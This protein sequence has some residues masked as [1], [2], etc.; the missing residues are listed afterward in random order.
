MRLKDRELLDVMV[1]NRKLGMT[2]VRPSLVSASQPTHAR[3]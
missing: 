3:R 2:T 1:E